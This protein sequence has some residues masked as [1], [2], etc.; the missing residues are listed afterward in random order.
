MALFGLLDRWTKGGDRDIADFWCNPHHLIDDR[1]GSK[2]EIIAGYAGDSGIV[3]PDAEGLEIFTLR[4]GVDDERPVVVS[5]NYKKRRAIVEVED[6]AGVPR[7]SRNDFYQRSRKSELA[8]HRVQE[9]RRLL[10][11]MQVRRGETP[12]FR[13]N[14]YGWMELKSPNDLHRLMNAINQ[15]KKSDL[16][17]KSI[18]YESLVNTLQILYPD[19]DYSEIA[20]HIPVN[21]KIN[22][23]EKIVEGGVNGI[24][25]KYLKDD[26]GEYYRKFGDSFF[27]KN[28]VVR[29]MLVWADKLPNRYMWPITPSPTDMT[30]T[31][32]MASMESMS[33][34]EE[35]IVPMGVVSDYLKL[36]REIYFKLRGRFGMLDVSK[37][38][39]DPFM[40]DALNTA[41]SWAVM[42]QY[43]DLPL[44]NNPGWPLIHKPSVMRDML[45]KS[46]SLDT[47][48]KYGRRIIENALLQY[49]SNFPIHGKW[50]ERKPTIVAFG[51]VRLANKRFARNGYMMENNIN[52]LAD[53]AFTR[54]STE[55]IDLARQDAPVAVLPFYQLMTLEMHE[56]LSNK[57]G[58]DLKYTGEQKYQIVNE[59]VAASLDTAI[60]LSLFMSKN[61]VG[62]ETFYLNRIPE[63][64]K[65]NTDAHRGDGCQI[66]VPCYLT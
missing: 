4:Y 63:L 21:V 57:F 50:D 52:Y 58:R 38:E 26:G 27:I 19:A 47:V 14:F 16:K 11:D 10:P 23:I 61:G 17:E 5:V 65:L 35:G 30:K 24:I 46:L 48:G 55:L 51:D 42:H 22:S 45:D 54:L 41:L 28:Q 32:N 37:M 12:A 9:L 7:L 1:S 29:D 3:A 15:V 8:I 43:K 25:V 13:T 39:K 64:T 49:E 56:L 36:R 20:D 59:A 44:F 2:L 6:Y 60:R 62:N 40:T 66:N 31:R 33:G 18:T 34:S 53:S